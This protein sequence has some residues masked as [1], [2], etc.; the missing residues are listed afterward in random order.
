[1]IVFHFCKNCTYLLNSAI[2]RNAT[3]KNGVVNTTPSLG[4]NTFIGKVFKKSKIQKKLVIVQLFIN[5]LL[6]NPF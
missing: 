4:G 3:N 5:T 1:M 2:V 6:F